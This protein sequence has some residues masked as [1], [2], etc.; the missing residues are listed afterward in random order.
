MMKKNKNEGF[1]LVELIVVIVILAILIG[2]SIEGIYTYVNQSRI[3]TDINN[4][5]TLTSALNTTV[6]SKEVTYW[7]KKSN[8]THIMTWS[9]DDNGIA[10]HGFGAD[11]FIPASDSNAGTMANYSWGYLISK[12]VTQD[13]NL[14]QSYKDGEN[15]KS[16]SVL[17]YSK[18]GKGFVIIVT[19]DGKGTA[20]FHCYALCDLTNEDIDNLITQYN[21][22]ESEQSWIKNKGGK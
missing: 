3:N 6:A 7:A 20:E 2:V 1:T 16:Y 19:R 4:A 9:Y 5:S 14:Q 12:H 15:G 21:I 22:T 17:P 13:S 10:E 18:T 11:Y 8:E